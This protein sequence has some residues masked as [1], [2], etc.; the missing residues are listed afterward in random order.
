MNSEPSFTHLFLQ[1][2]APASGEGPAVDLPARV[3]SWLNRVCIY[4]GLRE[5]E[6][7]AGE[8]AAF[9]AYALAFPRAFQ[10]LLDSY[11]VRR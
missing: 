1:M 4:L 11:S 3:N 5:Q 8:R 6:P 10:G 7:H 9:V 2:L